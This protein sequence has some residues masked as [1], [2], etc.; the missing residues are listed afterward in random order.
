ME[1]ELE[2]RKASES[3][4]SQLQ[5]ELEQMRYERDDA[6]RARDI[7]VVQNREYVEKTANLERQYETAVAD[8]DSTTRE[9]VEIQKTLDAAATQNREYAEKM[10][11]LQSQYETAVANVDLTTRENVEIQRALDATTMQNRKQ[12]EKFDEVQQQYAATLADMGSLKCTQ[13]YRD[14]ELINVRKKYSEEISGITQ[15]LEVR[16]G[17]VVKCS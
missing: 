4:L 13:A 7:T 8:A 11:N 6:Q 12:M 17:V 10:A 1:A 14:T 2:G 5:S 15:E 3:R 16:L 9:K